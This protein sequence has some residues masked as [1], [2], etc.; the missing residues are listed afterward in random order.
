MMTHGCFYI[1]ET[2]I[3]LREPNNS[4]RDLKIN[5]L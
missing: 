5:E 4:L 1:A 2:Y 3:T